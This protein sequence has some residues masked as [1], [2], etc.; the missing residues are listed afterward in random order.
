VPSDELSEER[1]SQIMEAAIA[2]FARRGFHATRMEDIARASG[3]SKGALYLYYRGKDTLIAAI[4]RTMLAWE[5]R[6]ARAAVA[7]GGS[8]TE[9]LLAIAAMFVAE[10]ERIAGAMPI[11]LEFYAVAARQPAVRASLS[12]SYVEFREV[13]A[14][15]VR[16]GI[17]SGEF[18]DT[19]PGAVAFTIIALMEGQGLLW[20]I[21]PQDDDW[22]AH[23]M[24]AVRLLL[25]GLRAR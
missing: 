19:D 13:L 3:L 2:E 20:A 22:R 24:A 5:L 23:G 16:Q 8:A 18:R 1:Q 10:I 15:V 12:A 7:G 25:D 21:V 11:L 9:R 6:A 17:A 4:M 14:E